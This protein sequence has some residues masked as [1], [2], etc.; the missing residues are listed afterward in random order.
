MT[1][2]ELLSDHC[3]TWS[4]IN[5]GT[6]Y[7]RTQATP[8]TIAAQVAAS[9]LGPSRIVDRTLQALRQS[10]LQVRRRSR[11]WP[12][13]LPLRELSGPVATNGL[14]SPGRVRAGQRALG[15]L[16]PDSRDLGR[17]IRDQSRTAAP[18]R[19]ALRGTGEPG[20]PVAHCS[21][22]SGRWC[23]TSGQHVDRHDR[24]GPDAHALRGGQ[25]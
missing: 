20:T 21:H 18:A 17:D 2:H 22:R 3:I 24:G 9:G 11:T 7:F 4:A 16:H 23:D 12:Q 19:I 6:N 15:Q 8:Q 14:R 5:D 13:V 1:F 25:Q 10:E